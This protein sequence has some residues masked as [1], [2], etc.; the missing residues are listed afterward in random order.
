MARTEHVQPDVLMKFPAECSCVPAA[1]R[2]VLF[3]G[4]ATGARFTAWEAAR[5][6]PA[7]RDKGRLADVIRQ[8]RVAAPCMPKETAIAAPGL[9]A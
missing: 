4:D 9:D 2:R 6:T 3:A 7:A 8:P 5:G 1:V